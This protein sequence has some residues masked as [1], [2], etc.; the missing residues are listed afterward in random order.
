MSPDL[1]SFHPVKVSLV[2]E[3]PSGD[4]PVPG[5]YC[6]CLLPTASIR[7]VAKH[8]RCVPRS[9]YKQA[10]A[11]EC[12]SLCAR[13]RNVIATA[14]PEFILGAVKLELDSPPPVVFLACKSLLAALRGGARRR[15]RGVAVREGSSVRAESF[16]AV[17]GARE[18]GGLEGALFRWQKTS[19]CRKRATRLW[20][21]RGPG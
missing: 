16:G 17:E 19:S 3:A 9:M 10:I 4:R 8:S 6:N 5:S 2:F 12:A 21:G 20:P 14:S 1:C 18:G 11:V 15:R 13:G 7:C